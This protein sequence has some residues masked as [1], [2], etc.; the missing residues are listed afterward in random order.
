MKY[1]INTSDSGP[2][3]IQKIRPTT[4]EKEGVAGRLI[5]SYSAKLKHTAWKTCHA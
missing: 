3:I 1:R 2:T 5:R 4:G